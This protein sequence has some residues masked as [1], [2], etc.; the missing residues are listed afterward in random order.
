MA[1]S[2]ALT[3]SAQ[4]PH[5]RRARSMALDQ[6]RPAVLLED[7]VA[8]QTDH[9]AVSVCSSSRCAAV[10]EREECNAPECPGHGYR[11]VLDGP[12]ADV[13]DWPTGQSGFEEELDAMR[14]DAALSQLA[15]YFATHPDVHYDGDDE[16]GLFLH[17][18]VLGSAGSIGAGGGALIGATSAVGLDLLVRGEEPYGSASSELWETFVFGDANR[19]VVRGTY[20]T[21]LPEQGLGFV[22]M[23]GG[24]LE[25]ENRVEGTAWGVPT[26]LSM[27]L[28][29]VGASFRE[30]A[31]TGFYARWH[32][33]VRLYLSKSAGAE[34]RLSAGAIERVDDQGIEGLVT[35]SVGGF[36]R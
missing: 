6:D 34:I 8:W 30:G 18:S 21:G 31:S 11:M 26:V 7:D 10:V 20:L 35:L 32:L 14:T 29:E 16:E 28:P 5:P 36:I 12:V 1:F 2:A 33:P 13:S 3:T 17:L 22:G 23:V 24:A 19:L 25:F 9:V 4:A 27:M 15:G